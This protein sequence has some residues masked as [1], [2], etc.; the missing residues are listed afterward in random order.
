ML[1]GSI[2]IYAALFASGFWIY[3][4]ARQGMVATLVAVICG[5]IVLLSWK[6]LR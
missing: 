3:G 6:N 2:M 4:E 1:I 5:G